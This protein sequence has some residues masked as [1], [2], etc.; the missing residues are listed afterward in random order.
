MLMRID[1]LAQTLLQALLALGPSSSPL[2]PAPIVDLGYARYR[3]SVDTATNTTTSLGYG[4]Q[5]LQLVG[6]HR[7]WH[8]VF[9][10][11]SRT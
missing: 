2:T 10:H 4:M 3:G 6:S 1:L 5:L 11:A 7:L 8:T 9:A